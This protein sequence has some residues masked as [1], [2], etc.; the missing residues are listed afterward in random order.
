MAAHSKS[1]ERRHRCIRPERPARGQI[2]NLS[3][4]LALMGSNR[5]API[6]YGQYRPADPANWNACWR[7]LSEC[8][9]TVDVLARNN[10]VIEPNPVVL[11]CGD[12]SLIQ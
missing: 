12:E 9:G 8:S 11:N 4:E 6:S 1:I 3:D 5:E 7:W 10:E 2:D